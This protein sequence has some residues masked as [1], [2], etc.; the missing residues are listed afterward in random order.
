ML[1]SAVG[2]RAD[3]QDAPLHGDDLDGLLK[4]GLPKGG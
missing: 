3:F 1:A 2:A 4:S